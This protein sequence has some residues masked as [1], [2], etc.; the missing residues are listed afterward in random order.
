VSEPIERQ[1]SNDG[2]NFLDVRPLSDPN[3]SP[4]F[5]NA[6]AIHIKIYPPQLV[7][8]R[9][10]YDPEAGMFNGFATVERN[11]VILANFEDREIALPIKPVITQSDLTTPSETDT[12]DA[13]AIRSSDHEKYIQE[14]RRMWRLAL[15]LARRDALELLRIKS[16]KSRIEQPPGALILRVANFLCTKKLSRLSLTFN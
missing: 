3:L 12:K 13:P 9:R 1:Q 14:N 6:G 10:N 2:Q 8:G 4:V 7:M 5:T 11:A 15:E 16:R